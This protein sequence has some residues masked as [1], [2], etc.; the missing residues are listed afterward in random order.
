M[1]VLWLC[2]LP[3]AHAQIERLNFFPGTP[4][5][6]SQSFEHRR[7][8]I[9]SDATFGETGSISSSATAAGL[10]YDHLLGKYAY[11]GVMVAYQE[12]KDAG[13]RYGGPQ[14]K[15]YTSQG[16]RDPELRALFRLRKDTPAR[17]PLD[18]RLA[19]RPHMDEREVG[20]RDANSSEGRDAMVVEAS[21]GH[22]EGRWEF[23]SAFTL[24]RMGQGREDNE[25]EGVVYR[26]PPHLDALFLFQLQYQ[27]SEKWYVVP[28]LGVEYRGTQ[29]LESAMGSRTIQS[30]TG[31]VLALALKRVVSPSVL[32][33][34]D[35]I[36][37]RA[38]YFVKGVDSNYDGKER[39]TYLRLS[40]IEAF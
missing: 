22:R 2:L 10:S 6:L 29:R 28:G 30:G 27:W 23:R 12:G 8:N 38:D 36:H 40:L 18:L 37:Q 3:L 7:T 25:S 5:V 26:L 21:H 11:V 39:T 34:L 19:Y 20:P 15:R 35:L 33:A 9:E 17:G 4:H 14:P 1:V 32:A 31:S 16:F 24:T 13:P